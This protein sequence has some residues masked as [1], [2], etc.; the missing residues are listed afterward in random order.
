[1]IARFRQNFPRLTDEEVKSVY[2]QTATHA[3]K[4]ETDC[5]KSCLNEI[6][7]LIRNCSVLD[8]GCGTGAISQLGG[9]SRYV[10]V[11]FV[12]HSLWDELSSENC[13][14]GQIDAHRLRYESNSFDVVICT[15]VLE[16]LRDPVTA[17]KE[18]TRTAKDKVVIVVPRERPYQAG[19]NL[20]VNFLHT[21]G[22][23]R[24]FWIRI[25]WT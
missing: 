7:E 11:D 14:F 4:V 9:Y 15:H 18:L 10:G 5:N 17:I 16:H 19:F 13:L 23:L 25:L 1:M 8:V 21:S 3:L 2:Q 24:D 22:R 6:R 20:H 12:A